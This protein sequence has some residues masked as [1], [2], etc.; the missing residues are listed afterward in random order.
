MKDYE[1]YLFLQQPIAADITFSLRYLVSS[2]DYQQQISIYRGHLQSRTAITS[3]L[4][5]SFRRL[6]DDLLRRHSA[7][8]TPAAAAAA[9]VYAERRHA[10]KACV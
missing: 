9:F 7:V 1:I 10:A 4:T 6:I 2:K 8:M 3:R 5:P